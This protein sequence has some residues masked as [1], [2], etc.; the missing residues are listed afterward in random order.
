MINTKTA[1]YIVAL[2][3]VD[4]ARLPQGSLFWAENRLYQ[5][6]ETGA[7]GYHK[8]REWRKPSAPEVALVPGSFVSKYLRLVKRGRA[9][10]VYHSRLELT[11]KDQ[12]T[13]FVF[14]TESLALD[15]A[16]LD[17]ALLQSSGT[18]VRNQGREPAF[19]VTDGV[20]IFRLYYYR[21]SVHSNHMD[22]SSLQV[23]PLPFLPRLHL[24]GPAYWRLL[25]HWTDDNPPIDVTQPMKP[26][27]NPLLSE[28]TLP[29]IPA[30]S[31]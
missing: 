31:S 6:T 28:D 1:D 8:A 23:R 11:E 25:E 9:L 16:Y 21:I 15:A 2:P 18:Y 10:P 12:P 19:A 24:E 30:V 27:R 22:L 26:V 5:V 14:P 3:E 17:V 7:S 29:H 20:H 4:T 13:C